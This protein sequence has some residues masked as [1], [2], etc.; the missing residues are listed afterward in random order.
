MQNI[1]NSII[2]FISKISSQWKSIIRKST[3]VLYFHIYFPG[4]K[5]LVTFLLLHSYFHC[6]KR[7]FIN[8]NKCNDVENCSHLSSIDFIIIIYY[9]YNYYY[10]FI[11]LLLFLFTVFFNHCFVSNMKDNCFY[12]GLLL[13]YKVNKKN[14]SFSDKRKTWNKK[15]TT[16]FPT[17]TI[18]T[19]TTNKHWIKCFVICSNITTTFNPNLQP[20]LPLKPPSIHDDVLF[21][22]DAFSCWLELF[23]MFIQFLFLHKSFSPFYFQCLSVCLS[24]C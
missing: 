11:Y 10:L 3:Q 18:L 20:T 2:F 13:Q 15:K 19:K 1:S 9:Y 8:K 21:I 4:R 6:N 7:Q 24:L 5:L 23:S 12:N 14:N 17:T 22:C 16:T